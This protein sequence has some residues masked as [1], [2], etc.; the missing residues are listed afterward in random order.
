MSMKS[1]IISTVVLNWNRSDLLLRTLTSYKQTTIIPYELWIVDNASTD[2]SKMIIEQFCDQTPQAKAIF[3]E[4]NIGGEAVNFAL[5]QAKGVFL[6]ISENDLEYLPNWLE[7]TIELFTHFP[8]LGQ[9]S[10]F[11]PLP[12]DDTP[13]GVGVIPDSHLRYAHGSLVYEAVNNIGTACVMRREIWEQGIRVHSLPEKEGILLPDD[14]RLSSEIKQLGYMCAYSSHCFVK[15]WGHT[16]TELTHRTD[17]YKNNYNAKPWLLEKGLQQRITH[18]QHTIKTEFR[19][20][21]L[22]PNE[23][24][25]REK[26]H[27]N[28]LCAHPHLWS[29]LDE[30]TPELETLELLHTLVRWVKP[31]YCLE[32]ES[33]RGITTEIIAT[34]LQHNGRGW[35]WSLTEELECYQMTQHRIDDKQ[36]NS[37]VN[38]QLMSLFNFQPIEKIEWLLIHAGQHEPIKILHYLVPYLSENALIILNRGSIEIN[39]FIDL[40][41]NW[42][43][44]PTPRMWLI[45]QFK[46][47]SASY[48]HN[49]NL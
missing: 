12:A 16:I 37:I 47:N 1:P 46:G 10:L 39:K 33:W 22:L 25:L 36:I 38:L 19:N 29:M 32:I 42:L 40:P 34:A 45:G 48:K 8:T 20:S 7:K 5:E 43:E 31:N 21:W 15:N 17:Y 24:I 11:G 44:F 35:L 23:P 18:W 9:L 6:H 3:L 13:G 41:I 26:S 49:M 2:D 27:P 30:R 28:N 4:Q 14:G